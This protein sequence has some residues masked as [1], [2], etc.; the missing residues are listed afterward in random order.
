MF[1]Q[2]TLPLYGTD[3][4]EFSHWRSYLTDTLGYSVAQI[5][6]ATEI[7][8]LGLFRDSAQSQCLAMIASGTISPSFLQNELTQAAQKRRAE[9]VVLGTPWDYEL[10]QVGSYGLTEAPVSKLPSWAP[11]F[12]RREPVPRTHVLLPFRDE[13]QLRKAFATCH[14]AIYSDSA[15]DPAATFDLLSLVIAAKVMDERDNEAVY[16]FSE[17][18]GEPEEATVARLITLLN[19]AR[20]WLAGQGLNGTAIAA[21]PSL[22]YV[23]AATIFRQLQDYSLTITG[24]SAVGTDLL[25]I[26]Y[27]QLVA[28]TF[29]GELG[30]YFTPTNIADFM[31]RL[32]DVQNGRVFDPSCGSGG[33][34]MAAL[35]HAKSAEMNS[36]GPDLYGNDIN[37]RMVEA[38]KVNY[39]IHQLDPGHVLHGDGLELARMLHCWFG[40]EASREAGHLWD[41]SP[42]YFDYV[43]ANPPFAGH[44]KNSEV[45][46]RIET[47]RRPDG[48][49][50]SLNKTLPFLELIVAS[51]GEGGQAGVVL[52]TSVLNAEE[53]SFVRFRQLLLERVELLAII[54]LPEK[55]FVHS[56]CGIHGAL[57]FFKRCAKPRENYDIFVGWIDEL[58]YDRLGKPTRTSDFPSLLEKFRQRPW[59]NDHRVSVGELRAYGRWDP[60]W[61]RLVRSLP[62]A[63]SED[64]VP[65]NSLFEIRKAR[66]SRRQIQE[67][68]LYRFFEVAD[69]DIHTGRVLTVHTCTGFELVKKGRIRNR[70]RHGDILLP[71]HRDSLMAAASANGRSVV[72]VDRPLD[73]LLTTDRFLVLRP[74]I[75]P[76]LL[77][78]ILNSKGVRRQLVAQCR[79]AAS[80]DI[81]EHTL[82]KVLVPKQLLESEKALTVRNLAAEIGTLRN[83]LEDAIIRLSECVETEFGGDAPISPPAAVAH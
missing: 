42:G 73:G 17:L 2:F 23:A 32:L 37:P 83:Q 53:E 69:T 67:N 40:S 75:D 47:A 70:V 24:S 16:R 41:G 60:T 48:S 8:L 81:R 44:E 3:W 54:G 26:A 76:S 34:L 62:G 1:T 68:E 10:F 59:S 21:V 30:S 77:V 12:S 66:W 50:R 46:K 63:E 49:V 65:L 35:R 61:L 36:K 31:A 11:G 79:G 55:A 71:N 4:N 82:S 14:D 74:K 28:S 38:A 56:D 72:I 33:L 52:P 25:G 45:L 64:F 58:G 7:N 13:D 78:T 20:Q 15:R 22:R 51:L 9:F 57:L 5:S 6:Q 29:R 39:L 80:L 18:K 27:E 19:S 43:L